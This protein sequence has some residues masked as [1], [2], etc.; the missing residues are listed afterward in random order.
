MMMTVF[1]DVAQ[2]S[3]V[4]VYRSFRGACLMMEA[5]NTSETSVNFY[6]NTRRNISDGSQLLIRSKYYILF[7]SGMG[8]VRWLK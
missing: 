4:E 5:A 7:F 8:Y 3:L 1:L 2:C 6:H